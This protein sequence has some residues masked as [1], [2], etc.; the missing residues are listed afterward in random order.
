MEEKLVSAKEDASAVS[1]LLV[2]ARSSWTSKG[3]ACEE[4]AE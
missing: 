2:P 4:G 3:V 1:V